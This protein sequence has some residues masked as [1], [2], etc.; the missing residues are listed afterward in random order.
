MIGLPLNDHACLGTITQMIADR[1]QADD[2]ALREIAEQHRAHGT[3][4]LAAWIRTLP[5]RDDDGDPSDGPKVDACEPAQR[6]VVPS[7]EPNCVERTSLYLGAA[8][9]IDP[10]PVR[11]AVTIETPMGAHTFPIEDGVPVI[12][13]PSVPR[14]CVDCGLAMIAPGPVVVDARDAIAWS[15]DLAEQG[16][17]TASVRNGPSRVRKGRNAVMRLVDQGAVPAPDEV[18]AMGWM[19]AL[20]EYAAHRYGS[21][22]LSMVRTVAHAISELLD[23]VLAHAQR[24]FAFEIGGTRLEA[25]PWLSALASAAGHIGLDVGAVALRTK[26]AS[27]GIGDDLVGLVEDE[28]NHEGLT[29]GVLAHPPRLTTFSSLQKKAA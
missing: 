11:Q 16:A 9:M 25:S 15:A 5:Q 21:R 22:A 10:V 28:L 14:N 20:A 19:F 24:N 8:E 7:A 18:E 23:E 1:V 13:D 27:M 12:L 17:G 26:L 2:P 6:L 29:L 4:G 3:A